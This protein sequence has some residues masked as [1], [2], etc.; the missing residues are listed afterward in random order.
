MPRPCQR[1]DRAVPRER[2]E[3]D[4]DP[5]RRQETQ[6]ADQVRQ[7]RVPFRRRG[8]IGR[9]RASDDSR[10]VRADQ[11]QAVVAGNRR[12]LV[13]KPGTV[14]RRAQEV[15]RAVTG[16]HAARAVSAVGRR[17]KAD[18]KDPGV[19]IAEP[20][21][22]PRP[23]ARACKP[24]R[25]LLRGLFPPR[26]EAGA[27]PARRDRCLEGIQVGAEVW[28]GCA[29]RLHGPRST[30]RARTARGTRT[31]TLAGMN[32][33]ASLALMLAL[34]TGVFLA[35]LELMITA[36]ALPAMVTDLADWT[37]LRHASWII[38]G[39][40]VAYVAMMPLAGRL[41]DRF[42]VVVP[43][44]I[45]LI[46]FGVGSALCGAAQNLDQL[47]A[48]RVLQGLGGGALV[49]LAT[50]GAS[51][52]YAGKDRAR[53]LG[54]IG[55]LTFLGMAAGPFVGALVLGSLDL[56]PA[57]AAAGHRTGPLVEILTPPWRWVFYID[58]PAASL[59]LVYTWAAAPGW[60]VPRSPVPLRAPL[61][62]LFTGGLAAV[63]VLLT[64][65]GS[66]ESPG[67][68]GGQVVL[69]I[70]AVGALV[71][72]LGL[73]ARRRDPLLDPRVYLD[74]VYGGA[75]AVSA[76]TGY[77][78]ATALI[79]G[80]V[81]VDRVL[82]GGPAEQRVALGALAGAMAIGALA[83]GW[84]LHR[85]GIV[86]ISLVGIVAAAAGMVLLGTT[87]SATPLFTLAATLALFGFG[88]GLTV[89]PRST[90]AVEA[91]GEAAYGVASAA[92]TVAR[93]LGMAVGLAVL[94]AFG[95]ERIESLSRAVQDSVF[96]DSVLP[97]ALRGRP[98]DDGLVVDVLERWA[99]GQAAGILA[100]IFLA[101]GVVTAAA[102]APAL[103]L[104]L[105]RRAA[106][107]LPDA[108]PDRDTGAAQ[109]VE[110]D[111]ARSTLAL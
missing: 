58:V 59:A 72:A 27:R 28:Q 110:G 26:D 48:A 97:A 83:S 78:L 11:G 46:A 76:L 52:L 12:G 20:G 89:S 30:A 63:L 40:L 15:G 82:Y 42:G 65:A 29:R 100:G 43:F 5:H 53:A 18:E 77:A 95:S 87:T 50:A 57:L 61:L 66:A 56:G 47:I 90:A 109:E 54:V 8:A 35:G 67:G 103:A 21:D 104:G 108:R 4:D 10:H 94:T 98:L 74:P 111:D 32:R 34:G 6:L 23:V 75:V 91:L 36:V 3:C 55:A 33:R 86:R 49:P 107:G 1:P 105:R 13:G 96:R 64:W 17:S 44:E 41:A 37:Q 16:E 25:P 14:E 79:G 80:A 88:F 51:H 9:G 7:A 31:R 102:L 101:A 106:G 85:T 68:S 71:V 93:M 99:A 38:N 84:I 2:A 22:G 92:V 60:K 69:L 70:V 39:Y 19:G 24:A 81:F 45:A 62:A 73:G